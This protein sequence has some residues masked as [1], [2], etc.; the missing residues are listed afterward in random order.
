MRALMNFQERDGW[1]FNVLAADARTV[2]VR[3]RRVR[4]QETLL[5]IVAKVGGDP[6]LAAGD[7]RRWSRGAVWIDLSSAQCR[8]FG[9]Q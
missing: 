4:D 1:W 7:I 2:L 5:R 3:S 9:I 8:Y 6:A